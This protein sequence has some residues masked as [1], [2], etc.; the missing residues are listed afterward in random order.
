MTGYNSFGAD[1]FTIVRIDYY[2]DFCCFTVQIQELTSITSRENCVCCQF[3]LAE[4]G[5]D[6]GQSFAIANGCGWLAG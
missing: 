6:K 5:P 4:R 2:N 1:Y 3:A